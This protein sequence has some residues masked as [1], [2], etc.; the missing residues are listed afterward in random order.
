MSCEQVNM[1][2]EKLGDGW[3]ACEKGIFK[4]WVFRIE[5][6]FPSSYGGSQ[7]WRG[8]GGIDVS[9]SEIG[10]IQEK[11]AIVLRIKGNRLVTIRE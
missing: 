10:Y 5:F 6:P 9:G 7:G 4:T 2:E 11:W 3:G 8:R 1:E